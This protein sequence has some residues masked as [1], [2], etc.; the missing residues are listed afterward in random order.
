MSRITDEA[1]DKD[2]LIRIPSI[3]IFDPATV[4]LCHVRMA[5]VTGGAQKAPDTCGAWGCVACHDV[6]DGRVKTNLFTDEELKLMHL[7]GVIR[8]LHALDRAGWVLRAPR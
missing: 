7:Q 5:N 1:R 8:T 6:I 4:V 3:C 2:C